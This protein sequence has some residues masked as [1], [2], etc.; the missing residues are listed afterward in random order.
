MYAYI[1]VYVF[2]I[3]RYTYICI[4]IC[5]YI[6]KERERERDARTPDRLPREVA[7]GHALVLPLILCGYLHIYTYTYMHIQICLHSYVYM[8]IYK[9][10]ERR[11]HIWAPS[12]TSCSRPRTGP[13]LIRKEYEFR[14]FWKCSLLHSMIL[15]STSKASVQKISLPV[16]FELKMFS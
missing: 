16:N 3:C 15:I 8:Y 5:V 2:C 1:H 13:A 7:H 4:Y 10:R 11:S 9:E 6:C 14:T 12:P